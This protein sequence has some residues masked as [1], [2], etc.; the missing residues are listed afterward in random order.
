ML[1]KCPVKKL[2]SNHALIKA[3]VCNEASNMSLKLQHSKC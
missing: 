2:M 1:E 3:Q